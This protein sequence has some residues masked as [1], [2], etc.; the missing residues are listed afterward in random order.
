MQSARPADSLHAPNHCLAPPGGEVS[1]K[2]VHIVKSR[3]SGKPREAPAS[4]TIDPGTLIGRTYLTPPQDDG[5]RYRAK[6]VRQIIDHE[7]G[8]EK[9]PARTKFLVSIGKAKADEIIAYSDILDYLNEQAV[10]EEVDPSEQLWQFKDIIGHEGPL[11]PGDPSYKGSSYNVLVAWEDGTQT[12][13]PLSVI[14]ADDF[15]TVALY[16]KRNNLLD[17]P[18]WKRFKRLANREKKMLRMANQT[19]LKSVRRAPVYQF[20][21]RVPRSPSEAKEIDLANGN[22]KWQD[23]QALELAQLGEHDT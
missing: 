1:S 13:E 22:T 8:I 2:P 19:K 18:G 20:G 7:E 3:T 14:A 16:G 4:F 23:A 21:F 5:Q 10:A 6:I 9:N 11:R 17:L 12:Y 15:V